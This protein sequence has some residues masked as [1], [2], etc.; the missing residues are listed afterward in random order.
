MPQ[1]LDFAQTNIASPQI[2]VVKLGINPN[3]PGTS[4]GPALHYALTYPTGA[5]TASYANPVILASG[6]FSVTLPKATGSGGLF[7]VKN[8]GV[9]TVTVDAG[10]GALI[11]AAQTKALAALDSLTIVDGDVTQWYIF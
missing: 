1:T 3:A 9:G 10:A 5:A 6:T 7:Y 8:I 4:G 11:D 2:G